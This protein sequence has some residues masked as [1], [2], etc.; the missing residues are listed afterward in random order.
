VRCAG[1][2]EE[3]VLAFPYDAAMVSEAKA[4]GGRYFDRDTRTNVYP[5]VRLQQV[6]A[7]AD[8][9]G[10]HVAPEVRALMP[11][12]AR[13][14]LRER[15]RSQGQAMREAAHPY[16]SH[17]LLTVPAWSATVGGACRCPR[18]AGCAR[19]SQPPL[20]KSCYPHAAARAGR[21]PY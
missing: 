13:L 11:A 4:I 12:A 19:L 14:V 5:F 16:L 8:A 20:I 21:K 2:G 10:I 6:V 1:Q 9:H 15:R 18:G 7:F 17:G 3:V